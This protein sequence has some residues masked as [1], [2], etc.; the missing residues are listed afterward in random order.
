MQ[1][2]CCGMGRLGELL[3]LVSVF[4]LV[5]GWRKLP[6]I[7]SSLGKS[8]KSFRH[9]LQGEEEERPSREVTE[10]DKEKN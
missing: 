7:G 5:F 8:L 9:G 1:L 4:I 3:V 10:L 6:E 2:R